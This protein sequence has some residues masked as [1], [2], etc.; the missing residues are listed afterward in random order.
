MK[1]RL[2]T[3]SLVIVVSTEVI[4]QNNN[5]VLRY[6]DE[7]AN[8]THWTDVV[9]GIENVSSDYGR[10][11]CNGCSNFHDGVDFGNGFNWTNSDS[12]Y[13]SIYSL[14]STGRILEMDNNGRYYT[15]TVDGPGFNDTFNYGHI[16]KDSHN[17]GGN[18]KTFDDVLTNENGNNENMAFLV[19]E[20]PNE[21]IAYMLV[22]GTDLQIEGA[23]FIYTNSRYGTKTY[24]EG[25][26]LFNAVGPGITAN[27][28]TVQ[29]VPHELV[30]PIGN[31]ITP[32]S[33]HVHLYSLRDGHVPSGENFQTNSL[34]Y[35]A[36]TMLDSEV[37]SRPVYEEID[38]AVN[39]NGT[40]F[41][42][43]SFKVGI[44]WNGDGDW[45]GVG[46]YSGVQNAKYSE[47]VLDLD[48]VTIQIKK[49]SSS[50]FKPIQGGYFEARISDGG[51]RRWHQQAYPIKN[52]PPTNTT[53][54]IY[55]E[56][57]NSWNSP[58]YGGY[59]KTGVIGHSYY[60]FTGR[61]SWVPNDAVI[62]PYE[63][64]Y[65]NDFPLRQLSRS[66]F[67]TPGQSVPIAS[68]PKHYFDY[69]VSNGFA[70][71]P[72]VMYPD[73]KY[74]LR[75]RIDRVP[76]RSAP[77][78]NIPFDIDPE[79]SEIEDFIIDNNIPFVRTVIISESSGEIIYR[80]SWYQGGG[81]SL[82]FDGCNY[83]LPLSSE[84]L[85]ILVQTS[86]PM[87]DLELKRSS[88]SGFLKP[89]L[90][91]HESRL[92]RF[93][94]PALGSDIVNP[95]TLNIRGNDFAGNSLQSN[96]AIFSVRIQDTGNP[97][98]DFSPAP[99]TGIDQTHTFNVENQSC[100][101]GS[102]REG[103]E[104]KL[105]SNTFK[106][107]D[108]GSCVAVDFMIS[109][110]YPSV[111]ESIEFSSIGSSTS[112][113]TLSWNFDNG[114][115]S[116]S[117]IPQSS[118]DE[119]VTVSYTDPGTKTVTLTVCDGIDCT[120]VT[121][122]VQVSSS[123][124]TLS[125]DFTVS[126]TSGYVHDEFE[127]T[128]EVSGAQGSLTYYWDLGNAN[129]S[130]DTQTES[131][132]ASYSQPGFQTISLTVFDGVDFVTE[133]KTDFINVIGYLVE[134]DALPS[135]DIVENGFGE[136]WFYASHRGG[137]YDLGE[138]YFWELS[139]G[140]TSNQEI[141]NH[142]FSGPGSYSATLTVCDKSGCDPTTV[143]FE[144]GQDL[145]PDR[146]HLNFLIDGE[147]AYPSDP[148]I[149]PSFTNSTHPYTSEVPYYVTPGS[150][151][152]I[153][154]TSNVPQVYN[155]IHFLFDLYSSRD[156]DGELVDW[157]P[158]AP[159]QS[160][161]QGPWYYT[162]PEE[163]DGDSF[164][165]Q[166][167]A[168][169]HGAQSSV[170]TTTVKR[171]IVIRNC[172]DTEAKCYAQ[173]S[174]IYGPSCV[175]P[176][177]VQ[178]TVPHINSNCDVSYV[179][180]VDE[181][182]TLLAASDQNFNYYMT[183]SQDMLPFRKNVHALVYN[184]CPET[185]EMNQIPTNNHSF[186]LEM[187]GPRDFQVAEDSYQI[188]HGAS[189]TIGFDAG[190]EYSYT[191]TASNPHWLNYLNDVSSPTPVFTA[192]EQTGTINYT[193]EL[194]SHET[195]CT[196]YQD[197][198]VDVTGILGT[199]Y[200]LDVTAGDQVVLD[201]PFSGDGSSYQY[202]WTPLAPNEDSDFLNHSNIS[203]PVFTAPGN[204]QEI[205]YQVAASFRDNCSAIATVSIDVQNFPP[206]NLVVT[207]HSGYNQ[208]N[209]IGGGYTT[210]YEI[211]RSHNGLSPSLFATVNNGVT[212]FRDNSC[213]FPGVEYCYFIRATDDLE[214]II[215]DTNEG[216]AI[217]DRTYYK[218]WERDYPY[219][220]VSLDG[221][222]TSSAGT[223]KRIGR[224]MV[225][226]GNVYVAGA[227]EFSDNP[228]SSEPVTRFF[229]SV[230]DGEDG[231]YRERHVAFRDAGTSEKDEFGDAIYNGS[232][233]MV[234][235][236]TSENIPVF[237]EYD[238]YSQPRE[239]VFLPKYLYL[240]DNAARH[241]LASDSR[242]GLYFHYSM[243]GTYGDSFQR[244]GPTAYTLTNRS[245]GR[246]GLFLEDFP[247]PHYVLGAETAIEEVD[248]GEA[249]LIYSK[250]VLQLP[251]LY[252][253]RPF[254]QTIF[255]ARAV[256]GST[257][258]G[259]ISEPMLV[260]NTG[261][262]D[263]MILITK[264]L[265]DIV[266]RK[267]SVH[268]SPVTSLNSFDFGTTFTLP[269]I[270]VN[271]YQIN[272]AF[273]SNNKLF[274][275]A[276][277][278]D[279][280]A[281]DVSIVHGFAIDLNTGIEIWTQEFEISGS[282]KVFDIQAKEDLYNQQS[283]NLVVGSITSD[284]EDGNVKITF[285]STI[286]ST[287][288]ST[289]CQEDIESGAVFY[290][291]TIDVGQGCNVVLGEGDKFNV[292]ASEE[293]TFHPGTTL[294]VGASAN[295]IV[296]DNA[297]LGCQNQQFDVRID[298]HSIQSP[299]KVEWKPDLIIYPNPSDGVVNLELQI[300]ER[301]E[302]GYIL[303][304]YDINGVEIWSYQGSGRL[305]DSFDMS[306]YPDGMYILDLESENGYKGSNKI[307]IRR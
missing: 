215:G 134:L 6:R 220:Q 124:S 114:S 131:P 275:F 194:I 263:D 7:D 74:D 189:S 264:E 243:V 289:I 162:I 116:S 182:G 86:E 146:G 87:Q 3:A 141:F 36:L 53:F 219:D 288:T 30:G 148:P 249:L 159:D 256:P 122:T 293:I 178:L 231:R 290:G 237:Y 261:N 188:C 46:N 210:R 269:G 128:A 192:L 101:C 226:T 277:Y 267:I 144:L 271:S 13:N 17:S 158:G 44:R 23:E 203:N 238:H 140:F 299:G 255:E 297:A 10:R 273:V 117:A 281:T 276:S 187:D 16:F 48:Q 24:T 99:V 282:S 177:A 198:A 260:R 45:N 32:Q 248:D 127:F 266:I 26:N 197:F 112:N 67:L 217:P 242:S 123:S 25:L 8:Q 298:N 268:T 240:Y 75:A 50:E 110:T 98:V 80:G 71:S 58:G 137:D 304:L 88:E 31:S 218:H 244:H 246:H 174:N 70:D 166:Y 236:S 163:T 20:P 173:V 102:Q 64:Y 139:D 150:T 230:F 262:G 34:N 302:T 190:P 109:N 69:P 207:G 265:T 42:N 179:E 280:D 100:G 285:F 252:M 76:D 83:N 138:T 222:E 165:I 68:E 151:I 199:D 287:P 29:S 164:W 96:P 169:N 113:I 132:T 5:F 257:L 40:H 292:T 258:S 223:P 155:G 168:N 143:H 239:M 60:R 291:N 153:Q 35:D 306:G 51:N 241:N 200:T 227:A 307:W 104:K 56:K 305:L 49:F 91:D 1:L 303:K 259:L 106:S 201:A 176:G 145:F 89:T 90:V 208:L 247:L 191:W 12:F 65:F 202:T 39:R 149:A 205:R 107:Q 55:D 234:G 175:E 300:Q 103:D 93:E 296:D 95:Q 105:L 85:E 167:T 229:T 157:F 152:Q 228:E 27:D 294:G 37:Y 214:N 245:P 272:D 125:V 15:I 22:D 270:P 4:S 185:G 9:L 2:L 14:T 206:T 108:S 274:I 133:T 284:Q 130:L 28:G 121:K 253:V 180:I 33:V 250:S 196:S 118:A 212:T 186:L 43:P 295:V 73:G 142:V 84:T 209:W 283:H 254:T 232:V 54:T 41:L 94:I 81:S 21:D 172:I 154:S 66:N 204:T 19:Y 278:Q 221:T 18:W 119:I 181:D 52:N 97:T 111:G 184:H 233:H 72:Y 57:E 120:S 61:Q 211:W 156:E 160:N 286:P 92:Y 170:S 235:A 77:P 193:L 78:F 147:M 251:Q 224:V 11:E 82:E 213:L 301:E 59:N 47:G 279:P 171:Q 115:A 129:Y 225:S 63:T 79:F 195:G 62:G 135:V 183:L 126:P 38:L 216:C 136:V 161:W